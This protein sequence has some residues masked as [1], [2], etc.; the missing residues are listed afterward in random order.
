MINDK[1]SYLVS[2]GVGDR[3]NQLTNGGLGLEGRVVMEIAVNNYKLTMRETS[4]K[5]KLCLRGFT[6]GVDVT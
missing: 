6:G 4:T 2:T 3:Q 1:G 5:L